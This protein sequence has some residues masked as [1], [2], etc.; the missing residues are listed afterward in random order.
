MTHTL[1]VHTCV[2]DKK[3]AKKNIR[4]NKKKEREKDHEQH[5]KCTK[6]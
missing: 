4:N 3:K 5:S 1:V 6:E 2:S